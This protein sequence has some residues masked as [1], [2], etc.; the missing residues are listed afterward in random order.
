[1]RLHQ[2]TRWDGG[3][4]ASGQPAAAQGL[5]FGPGASSGGSGT[6]L[7]WHDGNARDAE[8]EGH[9]FPALWHLDRMIATQQP[10]PT[11]HAGDLWLWYARRAQVH[12]RAGQL[13]Q[14]GADYAS[15]VRLG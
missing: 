5:V 11:D 10:T 13:D 9:V 14:A 6:D 3:P 2:V 4:G 7:A 12:E 1:E 15:A 8:Q